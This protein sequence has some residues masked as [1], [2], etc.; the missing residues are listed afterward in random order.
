[1][2][3]EI[4]AEARRLA[5]KAVAEGFASGRHDSEDEAS[6]Y[7]EQLTPEDR[8]VFMTIFDSL[9]KK[10]YDRELSKRQCEEA[11]RFYKFYRCGDVT[12]AISR[13]IAALSLKSPR[14]TYSRRVGRIAAAKRADEFKHWFGLKDDRVGVVVVP[15]LQ[16]WPMTREATIVKNRLVRA[17]Q[18]AAHKL[19]EQQ[20]I[21]HVYIAVSVPVDI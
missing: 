7:A 1:M 19:S 8:K 10:Y 14:D 17:S 18:W 9:F 11:Q 6:E 12:I 20:Q 13:N 5:R 16:F 15:S 4:A 2:T 3:P 21:S